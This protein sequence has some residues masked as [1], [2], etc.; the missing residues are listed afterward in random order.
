MLKRL[1]LSAI[2]AGVV[3]GSSFAIDVN[4]SGADPS[5]PHDAYQSYVYTDKYIQM[6]KHKMVSE[7]YRT[8]KDDPRMVDFRKEHSISDQQ[9]QKVIEDHALRLKGVVEGKT[10]VIL[11]S[12]DGGIRF[13]VPLVLDYKAKINN[14]YDSIIYSWNTR[15]I[16]LVVEIEDYPYEKSRDYMGK[17]AEFITVSDIRKAIKRAIQQANKSDVRLVEDSLKGGPFTYSGLRDSYWEISEFNDIK[18]K[19]VFWGNSVNFSLENEPNVQYHIGFIIEPKADNNPS[20][21][22]ANSLLVNYMLPSIKPL[23]NMNGYSKQIGSK[24]NSIFTYRV[25]NN[26]SVGYREFN[27]RHIKSYNYNDVIFQYVDYV[28]KLE[29]NNEDPYGYV[30]D[31]LSLGRESAVKSNLIKKYDYNLVWN[32]GT[33][34]IFLE[35]ENFDGSGVMQF[36]TQ[37]GKDRFVNTIHYKK[38]DGNLTKQQLREMLIDVTISK[39]YNKNSDSIDIFNIVENG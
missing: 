20:I 36:I 24:D 18:E 11:H 9:L 31:I 38:L 29:S 21:D 2:V 6:D 27:G 25:L 7:S 35:Q 13:T 4:I 10:D 34:G 17:P 28:R 19:D 1:L 22:K 37:N 3:T 23:A 26:S 8:I 30:H 14:P 5:I 16:P 32:D 15:Y 39:Q 33:P 12:K